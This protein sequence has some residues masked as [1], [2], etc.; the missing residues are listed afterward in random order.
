MV[1]ETSM[2]GVT[3]TTVYSMTTPSDTTC[4]SPWVYSADANACVAPSGPGCHVLSFKPTVNYRYIR[5]TVSGVQYGETCAFGPAGRT[6]RLEG[7]TR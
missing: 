7:M 1:I 3:F 6:T 2:D 4:M 5:G